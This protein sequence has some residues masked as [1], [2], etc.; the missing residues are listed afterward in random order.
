MSE[1]KMDNPRDGAKERRLGITLVL[2]GGIC[3]GFIGI[4]VQAIGPAIDP[5]TL[6]ILRLATA[7]TLMVPVILYHDGAKAFIIPKR[8]L[9]FFAFFGLGYWTL[10]QMCYFSAIQM[11]SAGVAVILLYTA[12]FFI[13]GLARVFLGERITRR[14]IAASILGV[15]GVWVMFMSWADGSSPGMTLGGILGLAAG[16]FFAT[17]FIYVKKALVSSSPFITAFY[18][19][20]F[21]CVFLTVTTLLFFRNHVYY[22]LDSRTILLILGVAFV[23]TTLGGT[24]NIMGLQRMEAGEAGVLGLI[25]PITT[26]IASWLIFGD[27][28]GGRQVIGALLVLTGA[29]LIY[30]QPATVADEANSSPGR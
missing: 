10:Y 6:S 14:K 21:G 13:I 28:L 24:L 1:T 5:L 11:T 25:E 8:N 3:W 17:Y 4:F 12:P 27:V 29:Y 26:L 30:K 15:T 16:F 23:S 9:R 2:A 7:S 20:A 18:S 19:M 22:Q